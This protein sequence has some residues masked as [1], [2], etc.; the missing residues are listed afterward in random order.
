[1]PN[2]QAIDRRNA[3]ALGIRHSFVIFS[4]CIC[5]CG[6]AVLAAG[7]TEEDG[8]YYIKGQAPSEQ[9]VAANAVSPD[10]DKRAGAITRL[11][12]KD[13]GRTDTYLKFYA[14]TLKSDESPVVR[15][16]AARALGRA[17]DPRYVPN[18]AAAMGD[19]VPAVR[20][21]VA[22]ALDSSPGDP[23]IEPLRTAAL[24]D[25][26]ID[27]RVAAIKAASPLSQ[28]GCCADAA[29]VPGRSAVRRQL[30]GSRV[31]GVPNRAGR[32]VRCGC[33]D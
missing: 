3:M 1:M 26:S 32:P 28:Q 31:A 8:K 15:S 25:S 10:P 14:L 21:D 29:E 5:H 16:A 22:V 17:A 18:L 23:A 4:F 7:C 27:V 2:D 33:L 9:N 13:W 24:K 20:C 12:S 30:R 6:L 19:R 11:S